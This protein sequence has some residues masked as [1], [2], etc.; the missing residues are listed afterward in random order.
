M[1]TDVN[2]TKVDG[3]VLQRHEIFGTKRIHVQKCTSILIP[4]SGV[5]GGPLRIKAH[6]H[7]KIRFIPLNS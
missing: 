5:I 7:D 6:A 4:A 2:V 3:P 1:L